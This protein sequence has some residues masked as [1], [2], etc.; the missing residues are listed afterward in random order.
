MN[1]YNNMHPYYC[2]I[3][4]HARLLYVCIID[5]EGNTLVDK[6]I[7]SDPD[8]LHELLEPYRG[9]NF[10]L[11]YVT[12]RRCVLHVIYCDAEHV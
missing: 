1:F 2:G 7:S 10:P 11:A 9:G 3:D 8:K 4:L 12:Q 6:E 5:Q